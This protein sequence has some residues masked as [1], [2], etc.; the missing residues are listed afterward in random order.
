LTLQFTR[1]G[2]SWRPVS[3]LK[4]KC[5]KEWGRRPVWGWASWTGATVPP[6][7]LK[8]NMF[9]WSISGGFPHVLLKIEYKAYA[10]LERDRLPGSGED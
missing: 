4:F 2:S 6:L 9:F 7:K 8:C 10:G 5:P 3:Y 1:K